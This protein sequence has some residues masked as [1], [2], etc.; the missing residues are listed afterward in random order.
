[1]IT[2]WHG[3][4]VFG[5]PFLLLER[6]YISDRLANQKIHVHCPSGGEKRLREL[7]ELA[8]PNSLN[9]RLVSN[10]IWDETDAGNV[11]GVEGWK[12]ERFKVFHNEEVDPHGYLMRH[13]SGFTLMHTGD[14]G[15][16]E[17]IASRAPNCDIVVI[18]LGV[19]D[20]VD[21]PYH[22]RPETLSNLATSCPDTIFLVTHTYTDD[23]RSGLTPSIT[24]EIPELPQNTIQVSDGDVFDWG[25]EGF[26]R[27]N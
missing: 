12:F 20:H 8:Y 19:P 1:M 2:H 25:S 24:D 21:T 17:A 16:C 23:P 6:K 11:Q 10:T 3:D 4:H 27:Y 14:S 15:P 13:N 9:D 5:F 22:F 26:I 18:E 7:C